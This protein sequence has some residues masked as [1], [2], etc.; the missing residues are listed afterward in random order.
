MKT[1]I[2][3][4]LLVFVLAACQAADATPTPPPIH[5]G[6]D[7]CEF[8]GMI[9]SEER[10]A[11]AY[12]TADGQAHLFDDIGDMA[13]QHL[14]MGEEVAAFFVHDYQSGEWIRGEEALYVRS[15]Q[16]STPMLSGVAACATRQEAESLAAE[17][18]GQ[19]LT[20]NEL[21]TY[22]RDNPPPAGPMMDMQ[23]MQ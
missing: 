12:V 10:F 15:D 20:F 1:Q 16:I 19:I 18:G 7:V 23:N 9:A 13:Q 8:C 2:F 17:T 14:K 22:Y 4:F 3:A 21:L 11:A 5:Y 6:E